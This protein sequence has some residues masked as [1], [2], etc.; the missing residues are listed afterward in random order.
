MFLFEYYMNRVNGSAP[1]VSSMIEEEKHE[2]QSVALQ[3]KY[4]AY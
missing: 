3:Y 1:G 2:S 4:D